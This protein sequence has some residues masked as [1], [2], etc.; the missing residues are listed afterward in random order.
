MNILTAARLNRGIVLNT[1]LA[2][3]N[4]VICRHGLNDTCIRTTFI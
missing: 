4:L 1:Q 2:Q 3:C